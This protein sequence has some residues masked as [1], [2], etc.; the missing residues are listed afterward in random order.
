MV[1]ECKVTARK[2]HYPKDVPFEVPDG[3]VWSTLGEVSDYG[4]CKTSPVTSIKDDEWVLELEDIEKDTGRLVKQIARRERYI[5]GSRHAFSK[6]QVLFSKLRTYLNKVLVAPGNGY[7]TTEIIPISPQ[8]GVTPEY[9]NLVLRSPY[10]LDYTSQCGYGVKMPRLGTSDAIKALIPIPPYKE[11]RR[12]V[13]SVDN[14][15]DIVERIQ[16]EKEQLV[17]YVS[18]CK[19]V[20]LELA[21]HGKLVPQDPT[22]EPAIEFL[23]RINPNYAPSD[24]LHYD[25]ELP[26]GWAIC[27]LTD[28]CG[29][30]DSQRRPVNADERAKRNASGGVKYPYYGATGQVGTIDD[31]LFDG[32]FILLGEDGAPFLEPNSPIAYPVSGKIWVNNHAHILSPKCNDRYLLSY[33]NSIEYRPYVTGTTRLKLT[34]EAMRRIVIALPPQ[35]EQVRILAVIEAAFKELD[36]IYNV[37]EDAK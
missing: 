26:K 8:N 18:D 35:K 7:C 6:G 19:S 23:R 12:I 3:W 37:L 13:E 1:M 28:V 11:Q 15:T 21:I 4:K 32:S 17:K 25:G 29:I 5:N 33:L 2:S 16:F 30:L 10:F 27:L 36:A 20:I 31:Y 14:Y 22:D 9:L 24:N 34:Q